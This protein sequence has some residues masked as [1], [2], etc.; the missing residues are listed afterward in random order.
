MAS[1]TSGDWQM[2]SWS[3]L[4]VITSSTRALIRSPW[5]KPRILEM[6]RGMSMG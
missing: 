4:A 1:P 6:A 3:R 2:A 5:V